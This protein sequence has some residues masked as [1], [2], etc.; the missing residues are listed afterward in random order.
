MKPQLE[1]TIQEKSSRV[2]EV[3]KKIEIL[4]EEC[5]RASRQLDNLLDERVNLETDISRH[6]II[7]GE[8][9]TNPLLDYCFRNFNGS[10]FN[11]IGKEPKYSTAL[12]FIP[13]V[14]R[15]IEAV[16]GLN[17]E[18]ILAIYEDKS[19]KANGM[20]FENSSVETG[21]IS[22]DC[23]FSI[24]RTFRY[25]SVPVEKRL[26][27]G[28]N[29]SSWKESEG[30]IHIRGDIFTHP[31]L[32]FNNLA[33]RKDHSGEIYYGGPGP[34]ETTILLGDGFVSNKLTE[35]ETIK[36]FR[37]ETVTGLNF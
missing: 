17:K 34:G 16:Q 10:K 28:K 2:F 14:E 29:S 37:E 27:L 8:Q 12:T 9:L 18:K 22:G 13:K 5:V 11:E 26:V 33:W 19:K 3:H 15:F 20:N 30:N 24:D 35:Y 21:V 32:T 36:V 23:E 6:M 4:K 25:L 7:C 31:T 1:G